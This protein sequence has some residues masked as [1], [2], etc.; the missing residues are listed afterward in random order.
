M[1]WENEDHDGK[2]I[3]AIALCN[4]NGYFE[5]AINCVRDSDMGEKD[6]NG[7]Y[8]RIWW[9][10]NIKCYG[11]ERDIRP[12][13]PQEVELYLRYCDILSEYSE[14]YNKAVMRIYDSNG[15]HIVFE[16]RVWLA[17]KYFVLVQAV[18]QKVRLWWFRLTHKV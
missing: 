10:D 2:F 14:P 4:P 7:V 9:A 12:A 15:T 17:R 13:T 5:Q 1:S 3:R 8:A 16:R 18:R 11:N 6:E